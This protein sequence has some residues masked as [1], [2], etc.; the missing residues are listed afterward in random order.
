MRYNT[1]LFLLEKGVREKINREK[2]DNF[3]YNE[4][5]SRLPTSY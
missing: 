4:V 2:L 1:I 5:Y 3:K